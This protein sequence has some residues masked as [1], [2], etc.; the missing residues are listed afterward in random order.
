[1][2]WPVDQL[3]WGLW[4]LN[5]RWPRIRVYKGIWIKWKSFSSMW[6]LSRVNDSN[7]EE[8]VTPNRRWPS[9]A[10][11]D[12]T[13]T[14]PGSNTSGFTENANT[15][16]LFSPQHFKQSCIVTTFLFMLFFNAFNCLFVLCKSSTVLWR[17]TLKIMMKYLDWDWRL[18]YRPLKSTKQHLLPKV[19]EAA[20][21]GKCKDRHSLRSGMASGDTA[22]ERGIYVEQQA[23]EDFNSTAPL[24]D[25]LS[26]DLIKDLPPWDSV[27][28]NKLWSV[29]SAIQ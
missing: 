23:Q 2:I 20:T 5:H 28:V 27:C 16:S 3:M 18:L 11:A 10:W 15:I 12:S 26:P 21:E 8:C 9:R 14:I 6:E 24:P 19:L 29:N 13:I 1:M 17:P 22:M 25:P 4:V 7:G